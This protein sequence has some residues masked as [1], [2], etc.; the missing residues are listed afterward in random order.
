MR[1][2]LLI[3]ALL[4]SLVSF[5]GEKKSKNNAEGT[6]EKMEEIMG[7]RQEFI[8][9]IDFDMPDLESD[10]NK[11]ITMSARV[12]MYQTP[13]GNIFFFRLEGGLTD[14]KQVAFIEYLDL[15]KLIQAINVLKTENVKDM[16]YEN[17]LYLKNKY[18]ITD[19]IEVGYHIR[20][21]R[22]FWYID[23]QGGGPNLTFGDPEQMLATLNYA[24]N[25]ME[26]LRVTYS[27]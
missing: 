9:L 8:K 12:R 20:R 11:G 17:V 7:Y 22:P 3:C 27:K 6:K 25:K 21:G 10:K 24:K 13:K 26:Q 16:Q 4:S 5:A 23:I 19:D 14:Q 2:L 15:C 18:Q 1:K